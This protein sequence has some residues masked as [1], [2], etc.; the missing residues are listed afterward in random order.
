M[1][2]VALGFPFRESFLYTTQ[3][4]FPLEGRHLRHAIFIYIH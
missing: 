3:E 2:A 1:V 4:W